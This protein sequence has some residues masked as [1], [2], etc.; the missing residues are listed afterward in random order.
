V[1]G[2]ARKLS[3]RT[4]TVQLIGVV[5]C[6]GPGKCADRGADGIAAATEFFHTFGEGTLAGRDGHIVPL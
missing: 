1:A 3:D 4:L 5:R 2:L 6:D